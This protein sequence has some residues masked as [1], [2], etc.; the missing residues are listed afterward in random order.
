MTVTSTTRRI[1]YDGDGSTY[2]FPY[3]FKIFAD[4]ELVVVYTD[5]AGESTTWTLDT[6]YTVTGAGNN[7]GGNVVIKKTPTNYTPA[8]GT[9]I[10]IYRELDILQESD[11]IE[12]SPLHADTLEDDFDKGVMID[13][14]LHDDLSRCISAPITDGSSS[15]ELPFS[16]LRANKILMFDASGGVI[17]STMAEAG[18]IDSGTVDKIVVYTSTSG[19]G[20]SAASISAGVITATGG[21]S[22]QWNTAYGWG[23]H[24]S[25]GYVKADGSVAFS[26]AQTGVAPTLDLH[27]STKK[28]VDDSIYTLSG[29]ISMVND[30]GG[31][32]GLSDDDHLQYLLR[33]DFTTSSGDIVAQIPSLDGYATE[34]YVDTVSGALHN[35]IGNIDLSN[36]YTKTEMTT[37]SGDIVDQIPSLAGYATTAQLTTTSGDIVNQIPTDYISDAEMT[38]ISGDIVGQIPS[39]A[40]YA[41]EAYVNTISDNI[42]MFSTMQGVM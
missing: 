27:I 28:Y 31:L 42:Y 20:P 37:I 5:I 40:G 41:T 30:H 7:S 33:T 19:V 9:T 1:I 25:G 8:A 23:N 36:Y 13:Q 17:T 15:L 4:D 35:E 14:Q 34:L 26:A 6:H 39:L 22:T 24:A 18:L 21:T 32:T 29:A 12:N 3:T 2:I 11:Y 16:S 10:T 38:V